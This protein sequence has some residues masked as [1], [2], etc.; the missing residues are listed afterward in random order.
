ML[1]IST[2]QY[3]LLHKSSFLYIFL[4]LNCS[5]ILR[6]APKHCFNFL[7]HSLGV[8]EQKQELWYWHL[9]SVKCPEE[10][11][12]SYYFS[13]FLEHLLDTSIHSWGQISLILAYEL[14]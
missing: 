12:A 7:F 8:H 10:Q 4:I 14:F 9:D 3:Q 5:N 6:M 1:K 2:I 13:I 11:I